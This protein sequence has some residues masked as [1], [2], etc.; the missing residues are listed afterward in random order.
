MGVQYRE[1]DVT[2]DPVAAGEMVRKSGQQGVPVIT[3]DG[4]VVV[5]FDPRRLQALI[6]QAARKRPSLGLSI[7]DASKMAMKAG[8]IPIFGAFVGRVAS[9]SP[10]ERA[11]VRSGDII[12]EANF[13]AITNAGDLEKLLETLT[14][15]S[16]LSLVVTRGDKVLRIQVSL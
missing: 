15:G 3:V 16:H 2:R 10:A 8:G 4:Q 1:I 14:A 5:G 9:G 13:R 11:G 12:T 7:A 6:G